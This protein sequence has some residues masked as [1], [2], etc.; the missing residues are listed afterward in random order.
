MA[1]TKPRLHISLSKTEEQ[2]LASLAKR[3][4][5]PRAT[6]AAQLVRQAMEIEE[7]F[8]L[9]K[10]AMERDVPGAPR[11]SAKAFWKA[12]FKKARKT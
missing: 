8:A 9:S 6:K 10:I 11:M 1:T 4:Q 5:V 12:A 7:D 3:D 2:F